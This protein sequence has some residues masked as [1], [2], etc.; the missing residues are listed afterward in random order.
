MH[1]PTTHTTYH[2]LLGLGPSGVRHRRPLPFALALRVLVRSTLLQEESQAG[3]EL[4][5]FFLQELNFREL[6][7][8][9][10]FTE[11][12]KCISNSHSRG[13]PVPAH[14]PGGCW[15]QRILGPKS[16][17]NRGYWNGGRPLW[18]G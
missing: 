9:G 5:V 18:G 15:K 7:L 2:G 16:G 10:Y 4:L 12:L 13:A 11:T 6:C 3:N 8:T 17:L 14:A 1:P